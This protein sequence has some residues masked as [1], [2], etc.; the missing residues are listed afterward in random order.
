MKVVPS[1]IEGVTL[2]AP[3][4]AMFE[5]E[6]AP[7]LTRV[8]REQ[9]AAAIPFSVIVKNQADRAIAMLGMRFDM[10]GPR[11]KPQSVV[12]Y[13]DSLRNPEKADLRPGTARWVCAEHSYTS[14]VLRGEGETGRRERLTLD[15]LR[16]M[17]SIQASI[18]SVVFDDGR[19]TGPDT[20]KAFERLNE[21]RAAEISLLE[22]PDETYLRRAAEDMKSAH[23]RVFA[24]TLLQKAETSGWEELREFAKKYRVKIPVKKD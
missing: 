3:D 6:L 2:I 10:L 18:D 1:T 9:I 5:A 13:A 23:R 19:F 8:T 21:E 4:D 14:L 24:R 7:L 22:H 16:Q 20:Q 11:A 17:L 15:T 12:H